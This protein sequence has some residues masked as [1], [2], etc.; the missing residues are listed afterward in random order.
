M[1]DSSPIPI[2]IYQEFSKRDWPELPSDAQDALASFLMRLQKNPTSPD[3]LAHSQQDMAGRLGY[4]FSPGYLVYWRLVGKTPGQFAEWDP[5]APVRIEVLALVKTGIKVS[6]PRHRP[7]PG[8]PPAAEEQDLIER[9]YSRTV[10]VGNLSMWGTLHASRRT[11]A[12]KGWIVDSW[13]Y[14]GPPYLRP[15]MHWVTFPDYKLHHMHL[16]IDFNSTMQVGREDTDIEPE[17]LVFIRATLKQWEN[18][19]LEEQ[20]KKTY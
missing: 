18:D 10:A 14:G 7:A 20:S 5:S 15:K 17:R 6:E 12:V 19:W 3:I 8:G 13:S 11:G 2:R 1:K 4:E 16:N 9:V